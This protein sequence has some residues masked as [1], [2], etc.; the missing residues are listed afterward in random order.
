AR[1]R[2]DYTFILS[3]GFPN[4]TPARC[5]WEAPKGHENDL[6]GNY[7]AARFKDA[8]QAAEYAAAHLPRLEKQTRQF[9]AA[10]RMSSAPGAVKDAA[11]A[12]LAALTAST[13]FRTSDGA[14]HGFEGSN[15]HS[16]CCFGSCTHVW[17][18]ESAT[19]SLFPSL[20]RSL[21]E[22]QFGFLTD[23]QGL[24]DFRELL[25]YGI[26]R[27]GFA[28]ADGQMGTIMK[29]YNDWRLSGD[30]AWLK[31]LWPTA[32]R[33]LE[34]AW[35]P[36]GWDANRDGVMEGVQSNTY[37]VEFIGPNPLCGIWYLGA[38]R[39]AEEMAR[40]AG[41]APAADQYGRLLHEGSKWID[42][43]LFNGEFYIQKIGGIPANEVAK[44]LRV[45]MGA[46]DTERPTFQLGDGCLSDQLVGQYAARMSGL[47]GLVNNQH[48]L[49]TLQS[50]YKFNYKRSLADHASVQRTYALN[51][52]A[53]LVICTYPKGARPQTPFP[54]FAEVWSGVEYSVAALMFHM[55][56]DAEGIEIVASARS[57]YDGEK[58]N[59]WDESECGYYY[60]RPMAGWAPF[61]ALSGFT[62]H[63]AEKQL[64]VKPRIQTGKFSSF[65]STA[66]A[67]GTFTQ[68]IG[69][70]KTNFV[71]SVL[72]G[73]LECRSVSLASGRGKRASSTALLNQQP[74]T[75]TVTR[76]AEEGLFEFPQIVMIEE[77]S[78]LTLAL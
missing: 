61:L 64:A 11:T 68:Q 13:C 47:G 67:W 75:H 28:A 12:T 3:W 42:A 33:A 51:N 14:F 39:A 25:P 20:S 55:G 4:R 53:G 16:G 24:M 1:G 48:V 38:L 10:I 63:G 69:Q 27:W 31:T 65:W 78:R 40:A 45:G 43:N 57:R 23:Q 7:Y 2:A 74:L 17:N 37:D 9:V 19:A 36:G 46:T 30:T 73:K 5:G 34:F 70:A 62:Y 52:E 41:D 54:Y 32:K 26:E 56:M 60:V 71:L 8:W 35:I 72:G 59:P 66:S 77:E 22:Q 15:E 6:I 29:L 21:R 76:N 18:Y 58:R 49:K 44:G 50:I